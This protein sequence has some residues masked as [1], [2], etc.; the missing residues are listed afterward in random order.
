MVDS[1]PRT[2]TVILYSTSEAAALFRCSAETVRRWCRSGV[3]ESV[4]LVPGGP[5]KIPSSQFLSSRSTIMRLLMGVQGPKLV[6]AID[7]E[8]AERQAMARAEQSR[9][10]R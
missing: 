2:D 5:H 9:Q 3:V 6:E 1:S 7:R 4:Q 8:H 10:D